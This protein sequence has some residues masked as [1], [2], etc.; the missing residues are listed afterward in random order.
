ML[1]NLR[2][3]FMARGAD[4]ATAGRRAYAVLF[5]MVER[6]AAMLSFNT[7]FWLL[8]ILFI[9]IVPFILLMKRPAT[10]GGGM[11]AH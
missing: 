11:P 8:A 9:A 10:R 7:A 5:G 2:R 3:A 4:F 1:E 6:Q